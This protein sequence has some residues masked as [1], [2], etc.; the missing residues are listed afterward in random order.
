MFHG[1]VSGGS[2][3][4]TRGYRAAGHDK[5]WSDAH[6]AAWK[7]PHAL[8]RLGMVRLDMVILNMIRLD[9]V[10]LGMVRLNM[11][12]LGAW[13]GSRPIRSKGDLP[14]HGANKNIAVISRG[15]GAVKLCLVWHGVSQWA[16]WVWWWWWTNQTD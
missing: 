6:K 4:K 2:R 5:S 3:E 1:V 14:L 9:M 13:S 16:V 12:R 8:L 15:D 11:V 7:W 10:Q